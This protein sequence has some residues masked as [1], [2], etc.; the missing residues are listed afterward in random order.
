V[1]SASDLTNVPVVELDTP[2]PPAKYPTVEDD[3]VTAENALL[4]QKQQRVDVWPDTRAL[5][6]TNP[7]VSQLV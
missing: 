3:V 1:D 7:Y 4:S 2:E 6:V 5:S